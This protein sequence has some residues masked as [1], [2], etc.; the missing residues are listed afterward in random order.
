MEVVRI[1]GSSRE[2]Q[3]HERRRRG[4]RRQRPFRRTRCRRRRRRYPSSPP[5][6][7]RRRSA[8]RRPRPPYRSWFSLSLSLQFT[9]IIDQRPASAI[10]YLVS[11][12][13]TSSN[14]NPNPSKLENYVFLYLLLENWLMIFTSK[15]DINSPHPLANCCMSVLDKN[16][17]VFTSH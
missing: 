4:I 8:R 12:S 17:Y 7:L 10:P 1:N 6:P 16:S 3:R 9:V 11:V 13:V 15:A 5:R 2:A 14:F